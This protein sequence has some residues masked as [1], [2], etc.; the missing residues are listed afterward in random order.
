MANF[1]TKLGQLTEQNVAVPSPVGQT[2]KI[3]QSDGQQLVYTTE[4]AGT[5]TSVAL[6]LPADL[7]VSGSPVTSSGTLSAVWASEAA[8][9]VHAAPNG[10]SGAPTW[11]VLAAADVPGTDLQFQIAN[12]LFSS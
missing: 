11:R 9:T 5:V 12:E 6:T 4:P 3:L 8:N 1:D 7:T 10:S 2:N